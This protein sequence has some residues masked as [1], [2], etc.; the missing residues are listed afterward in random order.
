MAPTDEMVKRDFPCGYG[1]YLYNGRCYEYSGWYWWGR[2]VFA[3]VVIVFF[4][5]LLVVLGCI[6]ARRRR[7]RGLQPMYGTGWMSNGKYGG[8]PAP[9]Q[10]N[11]M[12]GYPQNG[13][14]PGPPAYQQPPQTTG[15]TFNT[16]DGYYG[17]PQYPQQ[18]FQRDQVY[19]PPV[20]PPPGKH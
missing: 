6:S 12:Y 4:I 5:L 1:E 7:R 2:W 13:Y 18:T 11:E 10:N 9:G 3:G 8:A 15:T 20:G 17:A 19:E 16:G 14:Q